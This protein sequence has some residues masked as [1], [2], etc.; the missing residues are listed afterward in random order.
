MYALFIFF[1][2]H[3]FVLKGMCLKKKQTMIPKN[4]FGYDSF[5]KIPQ[6]LEKSIL[7]KLLCVWNFANDKGP[8]MKRRGP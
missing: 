7:G 4:L 8:E 1:L 3:I 5:L 6:K 2:H